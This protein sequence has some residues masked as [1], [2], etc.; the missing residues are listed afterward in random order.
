MNCIITAFYAQNIPFFH[1]IKD[2]AIIDPQP[3]KL[4]LFY[5]SAIIQNKL[6]YFV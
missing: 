2:S 6:L 3:G 1:K 4:V 5:N